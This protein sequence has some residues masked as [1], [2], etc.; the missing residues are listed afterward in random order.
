MALDP[1]VWDRPGDGVDFE[2]EV[3]SGERVEKV[4]SAYVDPKKDLAQRRW[5]E[6]SVDLSPYGGQVVELTLS[7]LPHASP[8]HDWAGWAQPV[9]RP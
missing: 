6:A 4:F 2:V 9:I 1:Q 8:D 3:R 7:T 5:T